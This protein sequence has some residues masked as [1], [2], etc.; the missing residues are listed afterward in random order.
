MTKK[1]FISLAD[2]TRELLR[3]GGFTAKQ[4]GLILES[5]ADWCEN[6]NARFDRERW[7][8]YVKG[9]CGPNAG[10][11][12]SPKS[13]RVFTPPPE[14]LVYKPG[15]LVVVLIDNY[16][17]GKIGEVVEYVPQY[18]WRIK[19]LE[20]EAIILVAEKEVQNA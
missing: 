3:V 5:L 15:D 13:P 10:E 19:M 9:E 17:Y 8:G 6:N 7:L 11:V 2:I 12:K 20:T 1:H 18:H 16:W 14:A 4:E